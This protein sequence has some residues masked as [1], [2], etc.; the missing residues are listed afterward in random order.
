MSKGA[1]VVISRTKLIDQLVGHHGS[2]CFPLPSR[3]PFWRALCCWCP[4]PAGVLASWRV[5]EGGGSLD[6][7][8]QDV[9]A[10][11]P[12]C[13][14]RED[15]T[16]QRSTQV[17]LEHHLVQEVNCREPG[18]QLSAHTMISSKIL[19]YHHPPSSSRT[20]VYRPTRRRKKSLGDLFHNGFRVRSGPGAPEK[21]EPQSFWQSMASCCRV[22]SSWGKVPPN[23]H[24]YPPPQ[25]PLCS[26]RLH[27]K[28]WCTGARHV[29]PSVLGM[30]HEY[31]EILPFLF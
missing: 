15:H 8:H 25:T 16:C 19:V 14:G 20:E 12:L 22:C 17:L 31:P 18:A 2:E 10:G 23:P 7:C 9:D 21:E 6:L 1:Y 27:S 28:G 3:P 5:G 30:H 11:E 24:I 13:V 4:E 26:W 29:H